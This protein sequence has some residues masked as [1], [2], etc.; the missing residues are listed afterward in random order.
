MQSRLT[1]EHLIVS[2]RQ[3]ECTRIA[4]YLLAFLTSPYP[5]VQIL[6]DT[7]EDSTGTIAL[8]GPK[9][10]NPRSSDDIDL[11]TGS[12]DEFA[13]LNSRIDLTAQRHGQELSSV[14]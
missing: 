13:D 11:I 9:I 4:F 5:V 3:S 12:K 7:L 8:E 14:D 2:K 1:I 6:M 10:T